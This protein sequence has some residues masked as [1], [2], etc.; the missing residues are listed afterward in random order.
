MTNV[1]QP[2]QTRRLSEVAGL[3]RDADLLLFRPA[4]FAGDL[5]RI[6]G[7]GR[8]SHAALAVRNCSD[9]LLCAEVREWYGGRLV[10][11][12]SQVE[13]YPGRIDV[14]ESN[15]DNRWPE[16]DRSRA[17]RAMQMQAGCSYGWGHIATT[18]LL[19]MPFVRLCYR[20]DFSATDAETNWPPYC[21]EAVSYALTQ[22]GV[23]PIP[24]LAHRWTEPSDL[25]RS[26]FFRYSMTL[27][28]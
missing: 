21:S 24:L 22:G 19:Y 23:D 27:V 9:V 13:R 5:I 4:D 1:A 18:S 8:Y 7:R 26:L 25:A 15:P 28:P 16:W 20:P 17:S 3:I 2:L 10:T 14:F 11:L 6:V 12:A